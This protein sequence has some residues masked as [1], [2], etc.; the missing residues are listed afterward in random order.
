MEPAA[1]R[2]GPLR[3]LRRLLPEAEVAEA[4]ARPD[5]GPAL[6]RLWVRGEARLKAGGQAGLRLSEW[7]D[8]DRAAVVA[9]A[10]E[11]DR[12]TR[13]GVTWDG[14]TGAGCTR[15]GVTGAGITGAGAARVGITGA[16]GGTPDPVPV[17][18]FAR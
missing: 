12:V 16:G 17:I 3:V 4:A 8:G 2:P 10:T 18:G 6:L 5:P 13:G 15:A 14:R 1:R 7:T 11:A 9:V